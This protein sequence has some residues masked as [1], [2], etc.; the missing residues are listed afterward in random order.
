MEENMTA[1]TSDVKRDYRLGDYDDIPMLDDAIIFNNALVCYTAAG[2]AVPASDTAGLIFAGISCEYKDNTDGGNGGKTIRVRKSGWFKITLGHAITIANNGDNVFV[3]D[4]NT[5]DIAANV[6]H[7][8]FAGSIASFIDTT[9][10]WINIIPAIQQADVATHIADTTGAHAASAISTAD[11]GG[12]TTQNDAE[13]QLQEIYQD[14][15]SAAHVI[16]VPLTALLGEDGTVLTKFTAGATPGFQQLSNKEV[17]LTW[18]GNGTPGAVSVTIPFVDPA[19]N[20]SADV[21]VHMFAKMAG[22]TDT[23]VVAFEAYFNAGDTDCAGTDPEVTGGVTLTEY[24]MTIDADDVPAA[25]SALTLVITPTAG[26]MD[27]D[28]LHVYA[29]WLEVT[30]KLRTA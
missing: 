20:D 25:P 3:A 2:Y 30:R 18:D 24:T 6:T 9:S 23:P 14:L 13:G 17:V 11:A 16:T 4:D 27:T 28:E 1:L 12:F 10:A 5:V 19:I 15:K 8:I 7:D 22:A 21:V 29:L 26:Q